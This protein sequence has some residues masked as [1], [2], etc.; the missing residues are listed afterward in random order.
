M[1]NV[2]INKTTG[3]EP[4]CGIT[5]DNLFTVIDINGKELCFSKTK[6]KIVIE[7]GKL[8]VRDI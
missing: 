6:H 1:L 3:H 7:K 4:I 8:W 2:E 5:G